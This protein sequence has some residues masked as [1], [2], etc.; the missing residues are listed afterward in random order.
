MFKSF[1]KTDI[2]L[3]RKVN[4][5]YFA[6]G[7]VDGA[8]WAIVC[9]GLGGEK[10]GDVASKTATEIISNYLKQNYRADM[11]FEEIKSMLIKSFNFANSKI[12]DM[13]QEN[14]D[15]EGMATTAIVSFIVGDYLHIV[16]VGDSRIYLINNNLVNQLTK[17]DSLVQALVEK[18]TLSEDEAKTHPKRNYLTKAV[19]VEK[20][21]DVYYKSFKISSNNKILMC[22]DGLYNYLD[23]QIIL[24]NMNFD[25]LDKK[26]ME[27]LTDKFIKL[28][29]DGGASDN[30][31]VVIMSDN[32]YNSESSE[33]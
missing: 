6:I 23:D 16:H 3:K 28:A 12:F 25:Y 27:A 26:Q 33:E 21:I 24:D 31:T 1:G 10:A 19:G 11:T 9:D 2:G 22:T 29:L 15:Y 20:E 8:S 13:G 7:V 17:D 32:Y 30:I 4:Q 18:G 5:D 14:I